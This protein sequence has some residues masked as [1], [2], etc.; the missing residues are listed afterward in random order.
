MEIPRIIT[1]HVE[2]TCA[3]LEQFSPKLSA[4][5]RNCYPNTAGSAL[6]KLEDG[7]LFV[8]TG[9]IPAMWLR[10]SSAQVNHYIQNAIEMHYI[11]QSA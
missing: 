2:K 11:V 10:D 8:L 9:D 5:Y 3:Q 4:L 7:S 6:R 1:E